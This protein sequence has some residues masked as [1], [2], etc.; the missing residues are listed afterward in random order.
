MA[1]IAEQDIE[2]KVF[3]IV[4]FGRPTSTTGMRA[5]DY[6]QVT[7]DPNTT[8]PSG[9]Y[10]RFGLYH[11]DEITGWQR[12]DAMTIVELLGPSD[13]QIPGS[14]TGYTYDPEASVRMWAVE[15]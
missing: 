9:E 13:A 2:E 5:A 11:G 14:V 6:Y 1:D 8:S 7:I 12:V 10:I 3:A 4:C 15:E